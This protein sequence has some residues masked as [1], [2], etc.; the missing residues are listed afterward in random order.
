[1]NLKEVAELSWEQIFPQGS[2]ETSIPKESFIRTAYSEFAFLT[3]MAYL[4]EKNQE[5]Y[6]ETPSYL[7]T[8]VEKDV[9][10]NEMDISDLKY[11]KSLPQEVWLQKIG[12]VGCK[13]KYVKSTVN[14]NQLLCDDD[15]LDDLTKTYYVLGKKIKFPQ[16]THKTPL[17]L[18]YASMG[19][20]SF[21]VI[22]VDEGISS[23]IRDKLNSIY[24]GKVSSADVTNNSNPNS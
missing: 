5:G 3:W 8:E 21:G 17:T 10:N 4:N 24:L 9:T 1:M 19:E 2:D 11:F 6:A 7:L 23:Q 14:L 20:D 18:T 12:E 13:C 15:S 22:E 16:G